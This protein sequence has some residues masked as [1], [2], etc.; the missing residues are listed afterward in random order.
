[1]TQTYEMVFCECPTSGAKWDIVDA[2]WIHG[3]TGDIRV[4]R[5]S[6][7]RRGIVGTVVIQGY[8]PIDLELYQTNKWAFGPWCWLLADPIE[9]PEPIPCKG[10]LGLWEVPEEIER[11]INSGVHP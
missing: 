9:L 10:S 5:Q 6:E 1:M 8:C 11:R 2:E 3:M 7:S 4:R